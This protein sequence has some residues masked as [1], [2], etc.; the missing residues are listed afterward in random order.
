[1]SNYGNY[2]KE[3][4]GRDIVEDDKGFATYEFYEESQACYIVD[5]YVHPDFRKEKV[6]SNYADKIAEIAKE[7]GCKFLYGTVAPGT[8]HSTE[9]VKVLL[10][11]GFELSHLTNDN[12]IWFRKGI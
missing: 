7:R 9:S 11:Y 4:L 1:M 10:G 8:N 6:A 3:R 5:I 12:L 2:I